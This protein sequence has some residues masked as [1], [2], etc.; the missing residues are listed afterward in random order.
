MNEN[1]IRKFADPATRPRHR[2]SASAKHTPNGTAI[3]TVSDESLRLCT[4]P[5]RS[6]GSCQTEFTSLTYQRDSEKPC[7][8]V[9]A[10]PAL[11]ENATAMKTGT[12]VHTMYAVAISHRNRALAHGFIA[13]SRARPR[14]ELRGTAVALIVRPPPV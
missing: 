7:H 1:N 6:A 4:R 14:G 12:S 11:N 9:C 13:H 2:S 10:F 8:V 3:S 5:E